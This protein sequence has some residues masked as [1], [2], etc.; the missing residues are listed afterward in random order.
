MEGYTFQIKKIK[1]YIPLPRGGGA[2]LI[3]QQPVLM[4]SSSVGK[5]YE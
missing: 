3:E 4:V 1:K 5:D 2:I